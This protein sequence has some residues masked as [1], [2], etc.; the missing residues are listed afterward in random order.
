M[1]DGLLRRIARCCVAALC[2]VGALAGP[3]GAD[4][5]S[6]RF[7]ACCLQAADGTIYCT[8]TTTSD[9]CRVQG[10]VW[11]GRG[12]SC[13][14][15]VC[16]GSFDGA[17]CFTRPGEYTRCLVVSAEECDRADGRF[18]GAHSTC[19]EYNICVPSGACCWRAPQNGGG[20]VTKC[21]VVTDARCEELRGIF[22]G[23]DTACLP[24]V[25]RGGACC[26]LFDNAATCTF[27]TESQCESLQG[28]FRG[29]GTACDPSGCADLPEG[30]CCFPAVATTP[31]EC[32]VT[33]RLRCLLGRGEFYGVGTACTAELCLP[34]T[35][36]CCLATSTGAVS[37]S[38][39][40]EESCAPRRAGISGTT[41]RARRRDACRRRRARATG[42]RT[43]IWNIPICS[44]SSRRGC[45]A[46]RTMTAT[47]T[48]TRTTC[49][50]SSAASSIRRRTAWGLARV[51]GFARSRRVHHAGEDHGVLSG[52][53]VVPCVAGCVRVRFRG[54]R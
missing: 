40:T 13:Y 11:R 34:P 54:S 9:R 43:A 37:C 21:Y 6:D 23:V 38:V 8:L 14:G 44:G 10:G 15:E 20:Y 25:C 17:C 4:P 28:V 42:T 49:A 24:Y 18:R 29:F 32:R 52:F 45:C 12:S 16:E 51:D 47:T 22:L 3:A 36:A 7:G 35:G 48:P 53:S 50:R 39:V 46:G 1:S 26:H 41:S 27:L 33:N 2:T 30:A 19:T 5:Y 31:P